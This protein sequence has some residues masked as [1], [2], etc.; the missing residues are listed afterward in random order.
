M[1]PTKKRKPYKKK[2]YTIPIIILILLIAFR[3]YLPTLV[4]NYVN[5]VLADI[6]GYY[7]HVEDIDI[8]LWR[9]AYTINRLYLNKVTAQSQVPFLNFPKTDISV[10][11]RALLDGRVVSEII[12]TSPEVI[13][14]LEDQESAE[15]TDEDAKASEENKSEKKEGKTEN[16]KEDKASKE[17]NPKIQG[18]EKDA[19]VDDWTKALTDLVPL[20]INHFEI[21]D[22]KL[23]FVEL[24]ADPNIDLHFDKLHLTMDNLSNVK[25]K[26]KTLP[27]PIRATAVSIGQGEVS[28]DGNINLI[29]EIPD[30][31]IAFS[32]E[33]ADIKALND[34][35]SYYA[36]IDFDKGT[37]IYSEV[38]IADGYLKGYV[39]PLLKDTKLIG[40]DDSFLDV[41]WEGF[42]GFF[43]FI[44]KN[45][46]TNTLATKVPFEGDLNNV[47]T[48][49]WSTVGNIFEN[50]WIKAFKGDV[51]HDIDYKD[52]F[53]EAKKEDLSK[54]EKKALRKKKREER[55]A[56]R[57][58][59]KEDEE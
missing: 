13:Y 23:A 4:K 36:G 15:S 33:D 31:D 3:I 42:V 16:K 54:K 48:S 46:G 39:K 21:F 17:K 35:T 50:A 47:Q 59:E 43:K 2:R 25:Q 26:E 30:M 14:V 55:R 12:M 8:S 20:D 58:K 27:S 37:F 57:K 28:L 49:V 18:A 10:Q 5:K 9:G 24:Q 56:E 44:L 53:K 52:A 19:D 40:K 22:G 1:A 7:G 29:K 6:P 32:L 34:F 45:Q 51:D 41:L 11:W 38:A